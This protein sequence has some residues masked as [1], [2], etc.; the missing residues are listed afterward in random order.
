LVEKGANVHAYN[1][2]AI[3]KSIERGVTDVAKYWLK[4]KKLLDDRDL[5]MYKHYKR[6]IDVFGFLI[7]SDLNY[8][9]N[10]EM[11]KNIIMEHE[12]IEFYE[13]FGIK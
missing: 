11:I 3:I 7:N 4:R 1:D 2:Y 5:L 8:F 9:I 13:K 6:Y 12:L 10:N